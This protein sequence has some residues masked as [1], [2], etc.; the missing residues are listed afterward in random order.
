ME[1]SYRVM[2]ADRNGYCRTAEFRS[3]NRPN[4]KKWLAEVVEQEMWKGVQFT[5][6]VAIVNGNGYRPIRKH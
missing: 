5:E 2:G 4:T 6:Y 1:K 3:S